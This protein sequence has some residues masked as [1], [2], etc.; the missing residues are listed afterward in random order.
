MSEPYDPNPAPPISGY[1]PEPSYGQPGPAQ[2]GFAQ[3][4]FAQPGFAQPA[5][6]QP[7]YGQPVYGP[8]V[9]AYPTPG[10]PQ[11]Y[12]QPGYPPAPVGYPGYARVPSPDD[13][14]GVTVASAV[15][16]FVAGGLLIAAGLL[17]L[18][19]ASFVNALS[20]DLSSDDHNA[21]VWLGLAGAA[22]IAAAACG[23]V[24]GIMLLTRKPVGRVLISIAAAIAAICA[25]GWLTHDGGGA[26]FFVVLLTVPLL[27]ATPLCWQRSVT[28]WLNAARR[29]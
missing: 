6:G 15:L 10:Y 19:G 23:I 27:V 26:I 22:N 13:R 28:N 14:P 2:P 12:G 1:P 9:P 20:S 3:P 17:L 16:G 24:G 7:A 18:M 4:G 25:I 5:Y 21:A 11:P 29:V 8:P